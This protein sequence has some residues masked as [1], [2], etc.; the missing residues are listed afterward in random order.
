V[1]VATAGSCAGP[2]LVSAAGRSNG[3]S[4]YFDEA[5]NAAA[6]LPAGA[7]VRALAPALANPM[8][9][10]VTALTEVAAAQAL[11]AAGSLAAVTA[12][13]VNAANAAV[14]T[15]V[16]GAG[17]T[18]D[19]LSA[20]TPWTAATAA[21]SL[22]TSAAD[23]YAY[24]LGAL[25][26]MGQGSGASPALAV[27]AALAADLADGT[28][29]GN[30]TGFIYTSGNLAG[31]LGTA[32][33]AMA[34]FASP[35]LQTAIN[36]TPPQPLAVGSFSPASGAA[37]ATVTITG[38]GFD[39]DPFHMQ[40]KFADNLAAE[41]VSSS[42]TQVVVK[43]P[44]GAVSGPVIV[45]HALTGASVTSSTAFTVTNP[46]GGGGG[47]GATTWVARAS[48]SSFM[49]N[50]LAYGAGRFVAVGFG[51]T[52]V[53]SADG[54]SWTAATAPD[55]NYYEAKSVVWTGSQFVMVGDKNFGASAPPLIATSP[56]ALAWTRRTWNPTQDPDTLADV[57]AGGNRLTVVGLNGS[58]A[59]SSDGGLTWAN[60]TGGAGTSFSGVADNGSVRV[61]VGRDGSYAGRVLVNSG[62]GWQAATSGLGN[63]YP[64]RVTWNGARFVA[65]GA[66]GI[67]GQA[68]VAT[69][70]DGA[71]WT[72][73]DIATSVV[74]ANFKLVAVAQVGN[75]L[76]ATGDNGSTRHVIVKSE[77]QGATWTQVYE[78]GT[79]GNAML[80]GIAASADR[81]VTVG[82]VK[83]VT[84]P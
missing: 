7:Q 58:L 46:G 18:L 49:L 1:T 57:A 5:L 3:S 20:P 27:A 78:A 34:A 16:L 36:V 30:A 67:G 29:N 65:V 37:G 8:T 73:V 9:M 41:V 22:G 43:V 64:S 82:G 80:A 54:L 11:A 13:Q 83:S 63:F 71:N 75:V 35:A 12:S 50:G 61:A 62:A 81:V 19:I 44:V 53:T 2:V 17:V 84:M 25:A 21:G 39:P 23:R 15:Q 76:Y 68:A 38:A 69:S 10:G 51:K 40:V 32:L 60:E 56:D 24:Y 33:N 6:P 59:T 66:G 4:T 55:N 14:V 31:Q 74:P 26:R 70:A 42:A 47:G 79:A 45:T 28:L 77:D 52:I 48:P 72:R